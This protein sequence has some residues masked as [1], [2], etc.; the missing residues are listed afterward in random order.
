MNRAIFITLNKESESAIKLIDVKTVI[1]HYLDE[2][3]QAD[4]ELSLDNFVQ[5]LDDNLDFDVFDICDSDANYFAV[6]SDHQENIKEIIKVLFKMIDQD[7]AAHHNI[8]NDILA[9][10]KN[11]DL[12]A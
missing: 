7:S 9:L 4:Q 11:A 12:S 6:V 2:F 3:K 8:V 5:F 10:L 1:A